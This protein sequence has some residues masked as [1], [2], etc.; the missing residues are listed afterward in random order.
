[1]ETALPHDHRGISFQGIARIL[2]AALDAGL[3]FR[4]KAAG[5]QGNV[6]VLPLCG[7][8][9]ESPHGPHLG[10]AFISDPTGAL[11]WGGAGGPPI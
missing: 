1:M 5:D 7:Q 9:T 11:P 10:S 4:T 2:S 8:C 6:Q 3:Q